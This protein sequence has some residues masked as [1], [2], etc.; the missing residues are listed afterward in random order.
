MSYD[1][2][3]AEMYHEQIVTARKVHSCYECQ[4]DI[5]VRERHHYVSGKW[6]DEWMSYRFCLIC[7]EI[8]TALTCDGGPM[9][10]YLWENLCE[11]VFPDMTQACI[12]K[13]STAA[14]KQR[15]TDAWREWRDI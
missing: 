5:A 8:M 14:A 1:G 9:F 3:E 2:D 11:Y 12:D 15:L 6:E 4:R 7:W 13:C 10:G